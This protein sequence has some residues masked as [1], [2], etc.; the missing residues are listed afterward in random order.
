[1]IV[2]TS[3]LF[4]LAIILMA[5]EG[6]NGSF[7]VVNAIGLTLLALVAILTMRNRHEWED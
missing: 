2:I 3:I 6:N 1:M 5:T 4:V 7:T